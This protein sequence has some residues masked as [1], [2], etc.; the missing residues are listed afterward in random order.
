MPHVASPALPRNP[1]LGG[2]THK[3]SSVGPPPPRHPRHRKTRH[4]QPRN[5]QLFHHQPSSSFDQYR[6]TIL[7]L[8]MLPVNRSFRIIFPFLSSGYPPCEQYCTAHTE[9]VSG[10]KN[11][12]TPHT[13]DVEVPGAGNIRLVCCAVLCCDGLA[14][15]LGCFHRFER[16][17]TLV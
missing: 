6:M 1:S 16:R 12:S 9:N 14:P 15:F 7:Q 2:C 10:P 5:H 13:G 11:T 17:H 8:T 3:S 4:Q